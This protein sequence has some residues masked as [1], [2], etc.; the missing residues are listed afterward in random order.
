MYEASWKVGVQ[1][2]KLD[3]ILAL[4]VLGGEGYVDYESAW[5]VGITNARL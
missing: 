2:G 4:S 5:C 3:L 1:L